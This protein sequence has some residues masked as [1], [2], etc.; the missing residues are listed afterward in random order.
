M[1]PAGR[2]CLDQGQ[3]QGAK[4]SGKGCG[5]G[6]KRDGIA[7]AGECFHCGEVGHRKFECPKAADGQPD[8]SKAK[9][10]GA[11]GKD[12][13]GKTGKT[14]DSANIADASAEGASA[15]TEEETWWFGAQYCITR[16]LPFSNSLAVRPVHLSNSFAVLADLND[17]EAWP[18][19]GDQ[20]KSNSPGVSSKAPIQDP[21]ATQHVQSPPVPR[22]QA[23][24]W[25]L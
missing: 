21:L 16:E 22:A 9:N 14:L 6:T 7:F 12:G 8:K 10:K 4:G 23:G 1:V 15:P 19:P 25:M 20:C 11:K 17:V 13:K 2:L 24:P 3:G 18:L 5:K